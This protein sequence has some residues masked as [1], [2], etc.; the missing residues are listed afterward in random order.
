MQIRIRRSPTR[1]FSVRSHWTVLIFVALVSQAMARPQL[2][3]AQSGQKGP[4][5][6]RIAR[7]L[8]ST[9]QEQVVSYWTMETGW[10][11]ELQLRNNLSSES[12]TVTPAL[13]ARDGSE[14]PLPPVTIK[15][16]EVK[17]IDIEAALGTTASQLVG[18][19]GSLVLRYR[20]LGA[21]SLYAA[22]MVHNVGHPFA[23]HID[24]TVEA[25]DY[26][27]G[28][29]EGI[30]W[31]P[32][33]TTSDYLIL[34]NQGKDAIP[35][36]LS[37]YDANGKETKLAVVLGPRATVRYS[38]RKLI[39][40]A[41]LGGSYGGIKVS[42][43]SHAGSLDTLHFLFD[44][45]AAFS[46]ILKMFDHDPSA[47]L[48]E[49][50]FA[51]TSVWTLRAPMLALSNPD[52]ALAFPLGT[53]LQPQL[54]IRNTT[55]KMVDAALRFNWR[56]GNSMGKASGPALHLNPYETRQIDVAALQKGGSLPKEANWTS[57]T[58]TT[59]GLPD[60]VMAVAAS[61]DE[62]LRYG[63]QT[64]FNDQLS[65][66]WEGGMWEYDAYHSSI[67]TA[68]NGG[69]KPT[70]AAF[71]IFYNQGTEKYEL[72]QTLKPDEQMWIEV[73]KLIREHV[74]DKAGKILPADL[75]MGSYELRDLT[76]TAV[77]SL[78]EGK[79][80]YDKTYGDAT[81]GCANCCSYSRWTMNYNPLTLTVG[82]NVQN[83][84]QAYNL[85]FG[86]FSDVSF[87]FWNGWSTSNHSIATVVAGGTTTGVGVGTTTDLTSGLLTTGQQRNCPQFR[88]S[89][90]GSVNVAPSI[91]GPNTLWWFKGLGAGVSGYANQITLTASSGGTGTS[92]QWAI[93]AG[94]DKVSLSTGTSATV[95]VT[96]IGQSRNPN[97]VSITV[98]VGGITSSPFN[99][100]VRAP[101]TLGQDPAHTTPVY[102][103]DQEY[104]W[105][106]KIY[107]QILD[108]LLTPMPSPVSA[109]EHWTSGPIPDPAYPNETWAPG[110]EGCGTTLSSAP[111]EMWDF[112]QGAFIGNYP[113]PVYNTQQ[114]GPAVYSW[115]DEIRIGTCTIGAGPRVQTNTLQKYTDH[116]AHTGITTPA[117]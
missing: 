115:G 15:P 21:R 64:P 24:A 51:E 95:Q 73:G 23:F 44:E 45:S 52:P 17:S 116:A 7:T 20:S 65:F 84:V 28:G 36:V 31:L 59:T 94:S 114:N 53:T 14:T 6:E 11:S 58:L 1:L 76:D 105:N 47:K 4:S 117:P 74:P 57:V 13:R 55:A 32:K 86:S 3:L 22:L 113:P 18:T 72:E 109:N 106:I 27:V 66:E 67:I 16:Q 5:A 82:G 56:N 50:D 104:V 61:Y 35:L 33:D 93:T 71:T 88:V 25:P 91:S 92:Y 26:Q 98:T 89:P 101:Y 41:G 62:T 81:Y 80:I 107:N 99:L 46:A 111:A 90:Q 60:E 87:S 30:W 100:T 49:R 97:D 38:V 112:I 102:A 77:G 8:D 9:D 85:C 40:D 39:L 78:F 12:L 29:R 37:L 110:A 103:Q 10:R 79:V 63:A 68:G 69:T 83:G 108:N 48:E 34:T 75:T 96:S 43:N 54:F 42:A 70:Q 19:Y 2:V